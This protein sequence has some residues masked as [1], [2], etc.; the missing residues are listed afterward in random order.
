M[1]YSPQ[2]SQSLNET[3][4]GFISFYQ[5][6]SWSKEDTSNH[7]FFTNVYNVHIKDSRISLDL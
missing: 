5:S 6:I 2:R 4:F 3:F 1:A 7:Y